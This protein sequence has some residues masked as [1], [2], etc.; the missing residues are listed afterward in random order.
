MSS[1]PKRFT[2]YDAEH[3]RRF[4]LAQQSALVV[5]AGWQ[6]V[7]KAPTDDML[8]AG[9]EEWAL[10]R[11]GALED[12]KEPDAIYRSMLAAAPDTAAQHDA[13]TIPP[14]IDLADVPDGCN[15]SSHHERYRAG[16]PA[17]RAAMIAAQGGQSHE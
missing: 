17:C 5:P 12:C 15:D 11:R 14:E 6:L 16:V 2:R 8:V 7:P 3:N 13:P 1:T 4:A 9:Q 10:G